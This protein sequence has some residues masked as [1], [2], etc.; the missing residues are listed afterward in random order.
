MPSA[1]S[2]RVGLVGLVTTILPDWPAAVHL[3]PADQAPGS[4]TSRKVQF[5]FQTAVIFSE[6]DE[7]LFWLDHEEFPA[8][9]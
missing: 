8:Q 4:R 6:Y 2:V 5:Y 1:V 3:T 7:A 9:N